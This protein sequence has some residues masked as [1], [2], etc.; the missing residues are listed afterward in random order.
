MQ[1][2][3]IIGIIV[4]VALIPDRIVICACTMILPITMVTEQYNFTEEEFNIYLHNHFH[5]L[6]EIDKNVNS[7]KA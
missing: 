5:S 3:S 2:I 4:A 1:D 7:N 6:E